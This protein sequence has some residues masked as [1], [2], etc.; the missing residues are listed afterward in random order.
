[1]FRSQKTQKWY[2]SFSCF[3][4]NRARAHGFKQIEDALVWQETVLKMIKPHRRTIDA[5]QA[6]MEG[7]TDSSRA[8]VLADL[9]ADRLRDT[10]DLVALHRPRKQD[11][12]TRLIRRYF[13][14]FFVVTQMFQTRVG[15]Q[16]YKI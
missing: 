6:W 5:V 8:Q 9:S 14:I 11:W 10:K 12:L 1:M 15:S 4:W 16:A 13:K 2:S 3:S 7:K